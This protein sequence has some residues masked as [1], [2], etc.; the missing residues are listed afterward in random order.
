D[1]RRP[2]CFSRGGG[3]GRKRAALGDRLAARRPRR[4]AGGDKPAGGAGPRAVKRGAGGRRAGAELRT[5]YVDGEGRGPVGDVLKANI[6]QVRE[7]IERAC[8]RSGRS[9]ADVTLIAVSKNQ[10]LAKLLEAVEAGIADLG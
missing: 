9:S 7:R 10:P 6:Q 8:A 4:G 2:A 1:A 5:V 3:A